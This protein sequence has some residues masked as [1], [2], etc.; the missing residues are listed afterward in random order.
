MYILITG[1]LYIIWLYI[2]YEIIVS[3]KIKVE[4]PYSKSVIIIWRERNTTTYIWATK[5]IWVYL[6]TT[7]PNSQLWWLSRT[8]LVLIWIPNLDKRK[9]VY[10][11]QYRRCLKSSR[12]ILPLA[13]TC[14]HF[15]CFSVFWV[16]IFLFFCDVFL[17]FLF[18]SFVL[19]SFRVLYATLL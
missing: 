6:R 19:S 1:I 5:W 9:D 12:N 13:S 11:Y 14:D 2:I 16:F 10:R 4:E 17:I 15:R 8:F 18:L 7:M 3:K